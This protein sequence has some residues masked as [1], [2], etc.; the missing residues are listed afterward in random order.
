MSNQIEL[1]HDGLRQLAAALLDAIP[2]GDAHEN[3]M[4]LATFNTNLLAGLIFGGAANKEAA[5]EALDAYMAD[6]RKFIDLYR[7]ILAGNAAQREA[8]CAWLDERYAQRELVYGVHVSDRAQMT[9]LVFDYSGRHLH[10][11]DGADG[12]LF[13]AAKQ[14]KERAARLA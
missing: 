1:T 12:G 5:S 13:L 10:F 3:M 9:C 7:H 6:V 4:M 11:I 14:F 8:L 2:N